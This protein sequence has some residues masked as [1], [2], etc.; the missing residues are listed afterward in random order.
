MDDSAYGGVSW[1][2]SHQQE[3]R[4]FF[5]FYFDRERQVWNRFDRDHLNGVDPRDLA[6][7]PVYGDEAKTIRTLRRYLEALWSVLKQL[8]PEAE[9]TEV[10]I[11]V[12]RY[13]CEGTL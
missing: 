1:D 6:V 8:A 9:T 13:L 5:L 7:L 2:R 10:G 3:R 4:A 12:S 11:E